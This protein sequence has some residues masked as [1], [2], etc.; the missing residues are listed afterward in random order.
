M[1]SG[2]NSRY[3]FICPSIYKAIMDVGPFRPQIK[4]HSRRFR[5]PGSLL[6]LSGVVHGSRMPSGRSSSNILRIVILMQSWEYA[7]LLGIITRVLGTPVTRTTIGADMPRTLPDGWAARSSRRTT[8]AGIDHTP[9]PAF[10]RDLPA[11]FGRFCSRTF[12]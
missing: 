4:Q 9:A 6:G 11:G 8:V 1:L 3:V 2:Y 5:R 12:A 10:G 7:R